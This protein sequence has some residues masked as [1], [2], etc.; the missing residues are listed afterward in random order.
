MQSFIRTKT[1]GTVIAVGL[2]ALRDDSLQATR[3]RLCLFVDEP[4]CTTLVSSRIMFLDETRRLC[5]IPLLNASSVVAVTLVRRTRVMSEWDSMLLA[6][7]IVGA[8]WWFIDTIEAS[9]F[10]SSMKALLRIREQPVGASIRQSAW[11]APLKETARVRA[12]SWPLACVATSQRISANIIDERD[13]RSN[14]ESI[15]LDA[16]AAASVDLHLS[17]EESSNSFVIEHTNVSDTLSV[18][19]VHATAL[20]LGRTQLRV[21]IALRYGEALVLSDGE[22]RTQPVFATATPHEQMTASWNERLSLDALVCDLPR[23]AYFDI[24]LSQASDAT[25][26]VDSTIGW[27]RLPIF[28]FDGYLLRGDVHVSLWTNEPPT[29]LRDDASSPIVQP[30]SFVGNR[31]IR[32]VVLALWFDERPDGAAV[33]WRRPTA[34]NMLRIPFN[35]LR[36]GVQESLDEI[37]VQHNLTTTLS[38]SERRSLWQWRRALTDRASALPMVLRAAPFDGGTLCFVVDEIHSLLRVWQAPEHALFVVALLSASFV[39]TEV[40]RWAVA[41]LEHI[42]DEELLSILIPLVQCV[43]SEMYHD[44]ALVRFLLRRA[45]ASKRIGQ[46]LYWLIT[47]EMLGDATTHATR[48]GLVLEAYLRADAAARLSLTR[49]RE[50]VASLTDIA[51]RLQS[52]NSKSLSSIEVELHALSRNLSASA[53]DCPLNCS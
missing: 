15:L 13:D 45:V 21:S 31:G 48:F 28:D 41:Q 34:F 27:A 6:R 40:R 37:L 11:V 49:Q 1:V 52:A 42:K 14:H 46:R 2:A 5:D 19:V 50:I 53:V 20:P 12:A 7:C 23:E 10:L 44:S 36:L 32:A 39:D 35:S 22:R 24:R 30:T 47:S 4:V 25:A 51:G 3:Y 17:S 8:R 38:A 18:R 16:I 9:A 26:V 43:K 29:R 33:V